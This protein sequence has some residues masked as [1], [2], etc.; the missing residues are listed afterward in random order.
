MIEFRWLDAP[1]LVADRPLPEGMNISIP[2]KNILQYR[3]MQEAFGMPIGDW[4]PW[5]DVPTVRYEDL[6]CTR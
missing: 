5:K 4:T 1:I 6:R 2:R 3:E